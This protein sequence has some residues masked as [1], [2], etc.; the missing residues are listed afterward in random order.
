MSL[1]LTET[2]ASQFT[3]GNNVINDHKTQLSNFQ[4]FKASYKKGRKQQQQGEKKERG[5]GWKKLVLELKIKQVYLKA[6]S[7]HS[8]G[9]QGE[10]REIKGRAID[11][12]DMNCHQEAEGPLA[13]NQ[14]VS[15][16]V[17]PGLW[18]RELLYIP[19]FIMWF[20]S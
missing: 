9:H 16:K 18:W 5:R 3:R 1:Q 19:A 6:S 8:S 10:E 13:G 15:L 12:L 2:P 20:F 14:S 17:S 11:S 4:T 7:Q